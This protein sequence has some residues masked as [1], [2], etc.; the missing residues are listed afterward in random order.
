MYIHIVIEII[1]IVFLSVFFYFYVR[2]FKCKLSNNYIKML[3]KNMDILTTIIKKQNYNN[4]KNMIELYSKVQ[5]ILKLSEAPHVSLFKYNYTKTSIILN[6]IFS[7]SKDGE[8][9]HKSYLDGLP[10]SSNMLNLEILN[11][12]EDDI[13]EVEIE[14]LKNIDI[15][16]Y[17]EIEN[18]HIKKIYFKNIKNYKNK[19]LGYISLCYDNTYKLDDRQREEINR[20]INEL[21]PYCS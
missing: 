15:K 10:V 4:V 20:I 17:K 18:K 16:I 7:I 13:H 1:I 19:P 5:T 9:T 2:S 21:M 8:M 12:D 6:F 3:N 14:K 11:C